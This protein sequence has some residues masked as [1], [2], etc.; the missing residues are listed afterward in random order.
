MTSI[1]AT[2]MSVMEGVKLSLKYYR[3]HLVVGL[4]DSSL[5]DTGG[6][7]INNLCS[8]TKQNLT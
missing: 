2:K 7:E 5:L 8:L 1:C 6:S 3:V 4:A